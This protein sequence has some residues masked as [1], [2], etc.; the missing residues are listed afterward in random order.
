MVLVETAGE[1]VTERQM[2]GGLAFMLGGRTAEG[3]DIGPPRVQSLLE[4]PRG[5]LVGTVD[6]L[7]LAQRGR[8]RPLLRDRIDHPVTTIA[9]GLDGTVYVASVVMLLKVMLEGPL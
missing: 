5:V 9:A 6:G 4:V 7:S 3:F 2:F 8:V 1:V